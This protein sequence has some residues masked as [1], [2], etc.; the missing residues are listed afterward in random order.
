MQ[1]MAKI[2]SKGQ[3]TIPKAVRE[4]LGLEKG[5]WVIFRVSED[6]LADML[7][8]PNLLDLAGSIA[9]PDDVRSLPWEEIQRRADEARRNEATVRRRKR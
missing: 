1:T 5:G 8:V 9:V 6:Q 7:P 2:T 4:A 3:I